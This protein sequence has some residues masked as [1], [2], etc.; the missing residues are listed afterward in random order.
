MRGD[1]FVGYVE[2]RI[3]R[4]LSPKVLAQLAEQ[5]VSVDQLDLAAARLGLG[6]GQKPDVGGDAGVVEQV[7]LGA[8][9]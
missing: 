7:T 1:D 5:Q 4:F 6:V 9:G 8:A 3:R 2:A